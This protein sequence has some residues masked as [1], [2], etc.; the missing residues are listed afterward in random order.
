MPA[1]VD[2]LRDWGW[3]RGPSCHLLADTEAEL[4]EFAARIGLEMKWLQPTPIAHFDLTARRRTLAVHAGAIEIT[5]RE[6]ALLIRAQR[7]SLRA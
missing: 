4:C 7:V 6:A 3:H 1:Y 5:F 2:R